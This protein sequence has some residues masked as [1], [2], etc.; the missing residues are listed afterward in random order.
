MGNALKARFDIA[1]AKVN[2]MN[3]NLGFRYHKQIHQ[4][5]SGKNN[6]SGLPQNALFMDDW[7][8][9][10]TKKTKTVLFWSLIKLKTICF[11]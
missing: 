9:Q 10:I 5:I 4:S 2:A 6:Y 11:Y 1:R 7:I 8:G 3:A